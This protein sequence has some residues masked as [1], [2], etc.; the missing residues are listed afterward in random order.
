MRKTVRVLRED[1]RRGTRGHD[2]ACAV[3]RA[4]QR[5]GLEDACTFGE[6]LEWEDD[7]GH[8]AVPLPEKVQEFIKEFDLGKVA[9]SKLKPFKFTINV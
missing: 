3:S 8:R 6:E 2:S 9:K 7:N 1:I 4:C 5:E